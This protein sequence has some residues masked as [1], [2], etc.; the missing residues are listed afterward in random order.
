M[1]NVGC[2]IGRT[3]VPTRVAPT[4]REVDDHLRM[5]WVAVRPSSGQR[6]AICSVKVFSATTTECCSS[7]ARPGLKSA[8][9]LSQPVR[10]QLQQ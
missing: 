1:V 4:C 7:V 10:L 2:S 6:S 3:F 8:A 5:L 9:V